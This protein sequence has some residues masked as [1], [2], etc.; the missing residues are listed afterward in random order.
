MRILA[1]A[2]I[3]NSETS[4]ER[5][6][7]LADASRDVAPDVLVLAGDLANMG[8]SF[9]T[10]TLRRFQDVAPVSLAVA[11]N[12]DLWTPAGRRS[13]FCYRHT[14]PA[15]CAR[16]GFHLLDEAP[17]AIGDVGFVGCLGWYDYSL[18]Q[19]EEPI[20]G[21]RLSPARPMRQ[22]QFSRLAVL[23]GREDLAWSDLRDD[24]F[25][26]KALLW[27]EES[28]VR[29]LTWNDA[30]FLNWDAEDEAIVAEQ[31]AHLRASAA[32]LPDARHLVAVTHTV[33]F[34]E[35][36]AEPYRRVEWAF[37]RAYMGSAA[38]GEALLD[39]PRLRLWITGHVHHQVAHPC[40]G[41]PTVNVAVAPEQRGSTPTL[42]DL[43]DDGVP[44]ITRL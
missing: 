11:G 38:L 7:R 17:H 16:H 18:R 19:T 6:V 3:H 25:R 31:V 1:L 33:P 21:V 15:V 39:D 13:I 4:R 10:R 40:R 30:I 2:D 8:V 23:P 24:D 26:G 12:H 27:R 44:T 14:L 28:A 35:A 36:F 32:A 41:I 9:F 29:S 37:C 22:S 42:I 34:A 43:S 5:V 20:P